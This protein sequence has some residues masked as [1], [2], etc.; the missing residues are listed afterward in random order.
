TE[1]DVQ[2]V[3]DLL[4]APRVGPVSPFQLE[5]ADVN[6]DGQLSAADALVLQNYVTGGPP[7]PRSPAWLFSPSTEGTTVR[8]SDSVVSGQGARLV[9]SI[10]GPITDF[11][12]L[13]GMIGDLVVSAET[14]HCPDGCGDGFQAAGEDCDDGGNRAGDGCMPDCRFECG[15]GVIDDGESCDDGNRLDGDSCPS[16]CGAVAPT[17]F[18]DRFQTMAIGRVHP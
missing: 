13:T 9:D 15:N 5:L 10:S 8:S 14:S 16:D 4:S 3:I 7:P 17:I 2:A 11:D 1:A 12:F 18:E 6:G